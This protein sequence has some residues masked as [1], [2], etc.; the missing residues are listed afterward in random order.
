[1]EGPRVTG[2]TSNLQKAIPEMMFEGFFK[3]CG[4]GAKFIGVFGESDKSVLFE[5]VQNIFC[6]AGGNGTSTDII[7]INVGTYAG[8]LFPLGVELDCAILT[9][10]STLRKSCERRSIFNLDLSTLKGGTAIINYDEYEE[11]KASGGLTG[12]KPLTFGLNKRAVVTAS[13]IDV[14]EI[15]CFNYCVQKSFHTRSGELIEP[16]EIPIRLNILGS[17][18]LYNALAAITCG[19]FYGR[20]IESIKGLIEEYKAP[21]R[22]FQKVYDGDFT[23][24]DNYCASICDYISA[25]DSIQILSYENLVLIISVIQDANR[26]LHREKAG[27]IAEWA[28]IL[29]CKEVILT[30]CMDSNSHGGELPLKNIRIYRRIFKDNCISFRYYHLLHHAIEKG[31]SMLCKNDLLV[32]LGSDEI[33]NAQRVLF[34]LSKP[35][36]M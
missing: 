23:I 17:S 16:F 27:L 25:F 31:L 1:M 6:K 3:N 34:N 22:H 30:S 13:S 12:I 24:I 35:H 2:V 4:Y 32:M 28:S 11:M 36:H 33:S 10:G 8:N 19:L 14:N 29:K 5:L 9:N 20:D 18:N 21:H 26:V 15:T 7:P